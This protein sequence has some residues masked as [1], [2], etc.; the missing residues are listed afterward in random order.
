V[1]FH[2]GQ[3]ES[4]G[5]P[6]MNPHQYQ[7]QTDKLVDDW[8]KKKHR[9]HFEDVRALMAYLAHAELTA[10]HHGLDTQ[11]GFMKGPLPKDWD[12]DALY[13]AAI[14]AHPKTRKNILAKFQKKATHE[15]PES[16]RDSALR[17]MGKPIPEAPGKTETVRDS[18]KRAMN[19]I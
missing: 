3:S 10:G 4:E 14:H 17:A 8:L 15:Q 13:E 9:P 11:T 6:N 7:Q 16:V 12:L 1:P 5:K 18:I 19:R 2:F